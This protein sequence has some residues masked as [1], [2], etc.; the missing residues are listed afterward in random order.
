VKTIVQRRN[1]RLVWLLG[2]NAVSVVTDTT[3]NIF[4]RAEKE[5]L[6]KLPRETGLQNFNPMALKLLSLGSLAHVDYHAVLDGI[7]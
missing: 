3:S 6:S 4:K 5:L 2:L 1:G 7:Y